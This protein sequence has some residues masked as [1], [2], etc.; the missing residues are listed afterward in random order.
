LARLL[1]EEHLAKQE[2]S[3]QYRIKQAK[4]PEHWTLDPTSILFSII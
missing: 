4:I 1:R 2:R 3:M